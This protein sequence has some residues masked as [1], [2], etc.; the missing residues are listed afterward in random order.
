VDATHRLVGL[1]GGSCGRY[2]QVS[3]L[4]GGSFGCHAQVSLPGCSSGGEY[5]NVG[6]FL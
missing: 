3:R 1:P 4:P 5:S 6:F 2:P